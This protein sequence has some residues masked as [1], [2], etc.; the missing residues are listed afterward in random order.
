MSKE[1][2]DVVNFKNLVTLDRVLD[3]DKKAISVHRDL[4]FINSAVASYYLKLCVGE[5]LSDEELALLRIKVNNL[6][7]ELE[8]ILSQ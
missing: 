1:L 8:V 5:K 3:C 4:S 6:I 2:S 7:A